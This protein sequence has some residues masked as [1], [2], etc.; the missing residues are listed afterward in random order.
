MS[1][2]CPTRRRENKGWEDLSV[3]IREGE[4]KFEGSMNPLDAGGSGRVGIEK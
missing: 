2:F 3:Q 4:N 1:G